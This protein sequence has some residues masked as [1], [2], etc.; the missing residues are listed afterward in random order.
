VKTL[1][2]SENFPVAT[3]RLVFKFLYGRA[4]NAC[5]GPIFDACVDEF[6]AKGT[7][8]SALALVAKQPG[9]CD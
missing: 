6:R 2:A 3:C 5:E 7:I 8:Q 9:F 1:V 4:E